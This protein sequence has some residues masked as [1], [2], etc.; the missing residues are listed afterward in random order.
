MNRAEAEGL[1]SDGIGLEVSLVEGTGRDG[2]LDPIG[3]PGQA[4]LLADRI[5]G[6]PRSSG[7]IGRTSFCGEGGEALGDPPEEPSIIAASNQEGNV[8]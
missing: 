3:L 7:C 5:L 6:L 4:L 2:Q 8:F 1:L